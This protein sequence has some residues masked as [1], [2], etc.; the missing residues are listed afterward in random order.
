MVHCEFCCLR[1]S[2][3]KNKT[4]P[5][6]YL[7]HTTGGWLSP[8]EQPLCR[9]SGTVRYLSD[10]QVGKCSR[11]LSGNTCPSCN[12]KPITLN[13]NG[14]FPKHHPHEGGTCALSE[15]NGRR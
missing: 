5:R 3:N 8:M 15:A 2:L 13:K 11:P 7:G 14:K 4:L 9:G 10:R 12:R 6:H 1:M